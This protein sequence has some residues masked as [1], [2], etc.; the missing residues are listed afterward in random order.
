MSKSNI[1][2]DSKGQEFWWGIVGMFFLCFTTFSFV[3][4]RLE[5]GIVKFSS[6]VK[7][8]VLNLAGWLGRIPALT[9][10]LCR[11]LKFTHNGNIS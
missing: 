2:T 8:L 3:H 9:H 6:H 10:G 1:L 7:R 11:L 4:E 5:A